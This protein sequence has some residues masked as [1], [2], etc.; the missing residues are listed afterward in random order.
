MKWNVIF[1]AILAVPVSLFATVKV[2]VAN[3][4]AVL[5]NGIVRAEFSS[6]GGKMTHFVAFNNGKNMVFS[7]KNADT[8][9][10]KDL[11][12]PKDMTLRNANYTI[13]GKKLPDGSGELTFTSPALNGDWFFLT[14][15]KKIILA[16]GS[17]RLDVSITIHNK[18]ERM[19]PFT[20]T[21]WS[22]SYLG[23]PG[24]DNELTYAGKDGIVAKV[25]TAKHN[26]RGSKP[27][28]DAMRNFIAFMGKKSKTGVVL[29]PDYAELDSFYSWYCKAGA[30]QDTMEFRLIQDKVDNGKSITKH[31]SI[32]ALSQLETL[33]G[34][35]KNGAGY[36]ESTPQGIKLHLTGF[37][38]TKEKFTLYINGKKQSE[39]TASLEPGKRFTKILGKAAGHYKVVAKDFDMELKCNAAGQTLPVSFVAMGEKRKAAVSETELHWQFDPTPEY[40]T[41]HY[42]WQNGNKKKNVLFLLPSSGSRDVIELQQRLNIM[43]TVPTVFPHVL[44]WQTVSELI[45][46]HENGLN[47]LPKY[48]AKN[49]DIVVVGANAGLYKNTKR[50][51]AWPSYPASV[52]KTLL[53]K[54]AAGAGLLIINAGNLD[55]E[56]NKIKAQLK[57]ASA[58]ALRN[59]IAL[60]AAPFFQKAQILMGDYGKGRIAVLD[61]P[62]DSY[63]V[64]QPGYRSAIWRMPFPDHRYQ[65][66]QF[67]IVGKL[68][69]WAGKQDIMFQSICIKNN[70]L[71]VNA[72]AKGKGVIE[73]FDHFTRTYQKENV[74]FQPGENQFKLTSMRYGNNYIH[75]T[76]DNGDFGYT[77]FHQKNGSFIKT[78]NMVNTGTA[79]KGKA[80]AAAPLKQNEEI[81]ISV[82]DNLDR[83]LYTKTSRD[84]SFDFAPAMILTNRH[85]I[86]AELLR[87]G[88]TIAE[89]RS[90]FYLP[91][92]RNTTK[93]YTN[94]LW[95]CGD[96]YPVY[97]Y[98][99]RYKQYSAFG[100]N[101]HY[102]G[103]GNNG[104]LNMIRYSD[105][106]SGSNGHGGSAIF[107]YRNLLYDVKPYTQTQDKKYLVRKKCPNNPD[108]KAYLE[109]D[110]VSQKIHDFATRRVFQLGDEM[111]MTYHGAAVDIC[112]CQYCMKEFRQL[113][114][115]KYGSLEKLNA[116]WDCKFKNPDA[117]FPLTFNEVILKDN[118]A[119][120][121][122]H[123]LFMDEV[124]RRSLN[125][126][127]TRLQ[128][129]YPGAIVG[130]TGV[131]GTPSPYNG[132]S[133]F[134]SMKDFECGSFY[135]DTRFPVSFNREGRLVMRYRGYSNTQ[136]DTIYCF[137]EGLTLGERSNN[138]WFGPIFLNPDLTFPK[139]RQ[140]YS[141]LLWELRSG[142]GDLLFHSKKVNHTAAILH[143]Q[144]S[145]IINYTKIHKTDFYSKEKDFAR[146]LEDLAIPH[147]FIAPEEL[148][149]LDQFKILMLPESSA[150]SDDD[151]KK[152]IAFVQ[153]GGILVADVEPATFD[154]LG[155]KRNIPALNKLFGITIVNPSHRK[156]KNSTF[157]EL[158]FTHAGNG[159]RLNG[160]K[161]AASAKIRFSN[162]PIWIENQ[163][164]KGKTLLLNFVS[165]YA[166][167][168]NTGKTGAFLN[169]MKAFL[170]VDTPGHADSKRPVMHGTFAMDDQL[171]F[172]L[173]P[174][175]L[176]GDTKQSFKTPFILKKKAHLYDVRKGKY[177]GF[178]NRFRIELT[179]GDGTLLAALPQ[180]VQKINLKQSGDKEITASVATKGS[181]IFV[182][183]CFGPDGKERK[184]YHQVLK[185][186]NGTGKFHIPLALNDMP[187]DWRITVTDAASKVQASISLK[188]N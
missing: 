147:R 38:K 17:S 31:F 20:F 143:S 124:F 35:G 102:S 91:E 101:F 41:P 188:Q 71:Q 187:G 63:L 186:E 39:F 49:Y 127:R 182:L 112:M 13:E 80:E 28:T 113:M 108:Q 122:E 172:A 163:A 54:C 32:A 96:R 27:I 83:H 57:P 8:G 165:D 48:L 18:V 46:K 3:D 150:L 100:F 170:S 19:S 12:A 43:P 140:Y 53:K 121:L 72:T 73:I 156:I 175:V 16:P 161:A 90:D 98:P 174:E 50:F 55:A 60:S 103:S 89:K 164:E 58:T 68:M 114:L 69:L 22:H 166:A 34:V 148:D 1:A 11:F 21:Y 67:A 51:G 88:K 66:Y 81:R 76:A 74:Q 171:F 87:D 151:V 159:V 106:E 116:A 40:K 4:T 176:T 94:M 52:R 123:R 149:Q 44:S 118:R 153:K 157:K 47:H 117:V 141:D 167:A 138:N 152:I 120:Y 15:V 119:P 180:K 135:N 178:G 128:K 145:L 23:I 97:S 82:V 155:R 37:T 61:F 78:I 162:V 85:E 99:Y 131:N 79:I 146:I 26:T 42:V 64:P 95:I 33:S 29:L 86:R 158:K 93:N 144:R 169:K 10:L 107:Y 30:P 125:Q 84:G 173:L 36:L 5:D 142:V 109:S 168:R 2:S 92:L 179:P 45:M 110:H 139:V 130:P 126:Y 6:Q 184:T 136:A 129:K 137:W 7:N 105:A 56:L 9:A 160:A 185:Y 132:N 62:C 75:V 134:Y 24:E 77:V 14:L 111:S 177:L 115:K 133:N 181:G 154:E 104:M 25:P 70:S 183:K 59:T 65:E